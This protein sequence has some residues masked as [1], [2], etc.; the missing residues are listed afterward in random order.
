MKIETFYTGG[1]I[2]LSQYDAGD[3]YY[4]VVSSDQPDYLSI[5][6]NAENEDEMYLPE[7]MVSSKHYSELGQSQKAMHGILKAEL[8]K[9]AAIQ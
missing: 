7:D 1:G 4:A 8:V 3:G 9:K 6:R 5:Y 2:W